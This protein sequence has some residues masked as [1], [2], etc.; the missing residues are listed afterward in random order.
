MYILVHSGSAALGCSTWYVELS[1]AP[2]FDLGPRLGELDLAGL[3]GE[4][5]LLEPGALAVEF[6]EPVV[7]LVPGGHVAFLSCPRAA[8]KRAHS[9]W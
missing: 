1:D 8:A 5:L 3:E 4:E 6:G 2:S 7:E 9:R